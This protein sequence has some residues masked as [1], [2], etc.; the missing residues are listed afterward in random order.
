MPLTRR[1]FLRTSLVAAGGAVTGRSAIAAAP[2]ANLIS[3]EVIS[4]QPHLYHGWPTLARRANGQLLLVY[5]GGREAHVCPFGRVDWMTSDDEG[6]SWTWPRTLLDSAIDDRD[7]GVLETAKGTILVTTFTS[8]AWEP[9]LE[10]GEQQ[11]ADGHRDAWSSAQLDRW[12]AVRRRLSAEQRAAELST[13]MI[14]SV[15]G[16]TTWS[17]RYEVPVNSPHGPVQLCNGQLLYAGKQLWRENHRVGVTHS[18]DDGLTWGPLVE[19]PPREGDDPQNYHELHAVDTAE[20]RI[21]VHIRNHNP[22]HDRET[23]QTHSDDGGRTWAVPCSI[24]VWGLPSHLLRLRDGRLL[25]TYGHRRPPLGNQARLSEDG[26]RTWSAEIVLSSDG[27]SG[28]LGYPSTVELEDGTLLT[29]WYERLAS[30]PHAVL[31]QARWHL[32]AAGNKE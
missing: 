28:D 32:R 1:N 17:A 20:G 29:V 19:I 24:G 22:R 27:A 21:I 6:G 26:G 2:S 9:I 4:V 25:M 14:R 23:L 18:S 8:S 13:W 31:R 5:S 11:F 15:D 10:Q 30:T 16:G 3:T 7:A 12:R